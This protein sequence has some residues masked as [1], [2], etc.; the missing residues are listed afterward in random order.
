[1]LCAR[2]YLW[3]NLC[4]L[5]RDSRQSARMSKIKNIGLDQC[6]CEP[7]KQQKFGIAGVEGVNVN[8]LD[9]VSHQV[10]IQRMHIARCWHFAMELGRATPSVIPSLSTHSSMCRL[11]H[12][13]RPCYHTVPAVSRAVQPTLTMVM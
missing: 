11:H 12:R 1:M 5:S 6:R 9:H 2:D 8:C 4:Y 3:C 13:H 7:F 10:L